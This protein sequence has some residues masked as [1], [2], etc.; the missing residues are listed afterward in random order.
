M[1]AHSRIFQQI[2]AVRQLNR[3]VPGAGIELARSSGQRI[4]R[5]SHSNHESLKTEC[6]RSVQLALLRKNGTQSSIPVSAGVVRP[7]SSINNA[8]KGIHWGI[9]T[10]VPAPADFDGDGKTDVAVYRP[11]TGTWYILNSSNGSF[12]FVNFGVSEDKPVPADY[13]GDAKAD[14]AVFRPSN[15]TWYLQQTTA[16]FASMQW[17]VGTDIP[18]ENAFVP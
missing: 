2:P 11:S 1:D 3:L 17:G 7:V 13:D 10:D 9:S 16:G 4:L 14:I 18:T 5:P 8:Q 15:G 12:T 6:E